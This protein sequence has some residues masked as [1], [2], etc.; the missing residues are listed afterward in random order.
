MIFEA[1]YL[2]LCNCSIIVTV[3]PDLE[4][5]NNL[6]LFLT[7]RRGSSFTKRSFSASDT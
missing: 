5:S 6:K 1:F 2:H 3:H 4:I 7:G